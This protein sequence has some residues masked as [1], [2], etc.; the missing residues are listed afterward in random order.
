MRS[1]HY[2][3]VVAGCTRCRRLR[4]LKYYAWD[5]GA[6]RRLE[7][8]HT[9][10]API[11]EF[12]CIFCFPAAA[13]WPPPSGRRRVLR[14]RARSSSW[15]RRSASRVQ[16]ATGCIIAADCEYYLGAQCSVLGAVVGVGGADAALVGAGG[17]GG[18][19]LLLEVR[20]RARADGL[21]AE[22]LGAAREGEDARGGELGGAL[23]RLAARLEDQEGLERAAL[24]AAQQVQR[25]VAP[26]RPPERAR[27]GA[28]RRDAAP[29]EP[30]AP[31]EEIRLRSARALAC[32]FFAERVTRRSHV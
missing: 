17:G 27:P 30:Q 16:S 21:F 19:A 12:P 8:F 23:R 14:L 26:R 7:A 22:A 18:G 2:V 9:I 11:H 25:R 4:E 24:L 29:T 13:K 6:A 15:P 31:V 5:H 20:A 1:D 32:A 10:G 3:A 28:R